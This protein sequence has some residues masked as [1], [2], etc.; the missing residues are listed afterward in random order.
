MSKSWRRF[1]KA[2]SPHKRAHW[3]MQ[4]VAASSP[5]YTVDD[6]DGAWYVTD[7]LSALQVR[8]IPA[9]ALGRGL[10][11]RRPSGGTARTQTLNC[12]THCESPGG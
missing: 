12:F 4:R 1:Q 7:G 3:H 8:S 10:T 11:A 5:A 6:A 2:A 9:L